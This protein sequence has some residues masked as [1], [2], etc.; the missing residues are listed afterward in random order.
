[1]GSNPQNS[2]RPA[3]LMPV[4]RVQDEHEP[5][6]YINGDEEDTGGAMEDAFQNPNMFGLAHFQ[7]KEDQPPRYTPGVSSSKDI[8]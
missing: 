7:L 3:V 5:V 6:I 4:K 2:D 8:R 1:M